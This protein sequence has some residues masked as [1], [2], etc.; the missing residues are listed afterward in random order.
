MAFGDFTF[1]LVQQDLG[2]TVDEADDEPGVT[3]P[4]AP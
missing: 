4:T 2:P 1:P 3:P